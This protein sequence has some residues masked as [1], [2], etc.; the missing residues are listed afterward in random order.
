M[1][2][3]TEESG[4]YHKCAHDEHHTSHVTRHTS[5]EMIQALS[6][7][8]SGQGVVATGIESSLFETQAQ[9]T[10]DVLRDV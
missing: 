2:C 7:H 4:G 5:Q 1:T 8:S 3:P 9:V 10:C 6:F